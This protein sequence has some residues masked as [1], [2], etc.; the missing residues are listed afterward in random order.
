MTGM[1]LA[2]ELKQPITFPNKIRDIR[3]ALLDKAVTITQHHP[4][5]VLFIDKHNCP[6]RTATHFN[7]NR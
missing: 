1:S 4:D 6:L 5:T 7:R 2:A 3:Q